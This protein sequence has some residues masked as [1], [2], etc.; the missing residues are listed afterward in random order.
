[1]SN[2]PNTRTW[3]RI[4]TGPK[5]ANSISEETHAGSKREA[6]DQEQTEL[7]TMLK[8]K[9]SETNVTE[10]SKLMAMEFNRMVVA[11]RQHRR[12]Q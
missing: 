3:K 8:K 9:K 1:M 6:Q 5:H 10:V 12:N 2:N 11:T 7:D 4:T